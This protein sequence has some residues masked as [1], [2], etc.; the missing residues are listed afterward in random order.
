VVARALGVDPPPLV[1]S[2]SA[3]N[4]EWNGFYIAYNPG[5]I[6]GVLSRHCTDSLCA[7]GVIRGVLGHELGHMIG[8]DVGAP[9]HERPAREDR[10]DQ[11]AAI[12][13]ARSGV[14]PEVFGRILNEATG[15]S[16]PGYPPGWYREQ[17]VRKVYEKVMWGAVG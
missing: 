6:Q 17:T 9:E 11:Y 1:A 7:S 4:A 3:R 15:F 8:G 12:A 16:A 13:L 2:V 14:S 10:A 5:W